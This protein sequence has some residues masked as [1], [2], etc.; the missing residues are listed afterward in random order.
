MIA[1]VNAALYFKDK[2]FD[3]NGVSKRLSKK[4]GLAAE[5]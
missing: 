1:L 5:K 3:A 4:A 2:F